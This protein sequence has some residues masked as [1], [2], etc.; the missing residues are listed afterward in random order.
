MCVCVCVYKC[1]LGDSLSF[2]HV[3]L[4]NKDT[5]YQYNFILRPF[6]FSYKCLS[7]RLELVNESTRNNFGK[8]S[9]QFQ[10][11]TKTLIR[12]IERILIKL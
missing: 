5:F 2:K 1:V 3:W 12:K 8:F 7:F 10:P 6:R 9:H 4:N 11:K